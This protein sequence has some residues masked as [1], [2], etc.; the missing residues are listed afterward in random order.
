M[1]TAAPE[2]VWSLRL[3][4]PAMGAFWITKILYI[5]RYVT[6]MHEKIFHEHGLYLRIKTVILIHTH[7]AYAALA[8]DEVKNLVWTKLNIY[9]WRSSKMLKWLV[10]Y[11]KRFS[12]PVISIQTYIFGVYSVIIELNSNKDDITLLLYIITLIVMYNSIYLWQSVSSI[13][14]TISSSF[15]K[16]I[17]MKLLAF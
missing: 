15:W 17:Y 9:I 6:Y 8:F 13:S 2:H 11:F 4:T 12:S 1:I 14:K 3:S 7:T 5:R 16:Y 10:K